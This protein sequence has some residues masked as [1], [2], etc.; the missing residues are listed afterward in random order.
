MDVPYLINCLVFLF[1]FSKS[2]EHSS[3]Y[4]FV[5]DLSLEGRLLAKNICTFN[6]HIHIYTHFFLRQRFTLSPRLKCSGM[7]IVHCSLYLLGS[8]NPPT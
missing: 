5:R 4:P 6:I 2:N 1:C 7:I 3:E 8:S